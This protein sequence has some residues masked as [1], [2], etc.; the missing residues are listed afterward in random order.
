MVRLETS[1][2]VARIGWSYN[3]WQFQR[4]CINYPPSHPT[5]PATSPPILIPH[6][7]VGTASLWI[8][9]SENDGNCLVTISRGLYLPDNAA[10]DDAMFWS[11]VT[12]AAISGHWAGTTPW[13]VWHNV[14]QCHVRPRYPPQHQKISRPSH[15]STL[16]KHC[17]FYNQLLEGHIKNVGSKWLYL[18]ADL[19]S[20]M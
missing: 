3:S 7:K 15:Q 5:F 11:N 12:W 18:V 16:T 10:L 1:F 6:E 19:L 17:S 14:R 9:I 4:L 20:L 13:Q 2:S 8:S